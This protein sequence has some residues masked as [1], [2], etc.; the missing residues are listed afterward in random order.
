LE[1]KH[2]KEIQKKS[3]LATPRLVQSTVHGING[4]PGTNAVL[5]AVVE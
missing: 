3:K 4:V 2:A 1:V 5:P